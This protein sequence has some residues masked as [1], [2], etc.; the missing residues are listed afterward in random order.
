MRGRFP[1][2]GRL[3]IR[4]R[5]PWRGRLLLGRRVPVVSA[6]SASLTGQSAM[7]RVADHF[8]GEMIRRIDQRLINKTFREGCPIG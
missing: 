2:R 7:V 3:P 4:G 8:P 6:S 1:M 5:F